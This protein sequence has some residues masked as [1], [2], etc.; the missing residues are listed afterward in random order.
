[1]PV[2]SLALK[3]AAGDPR[4]LSS[5]LPALT[6]ICSTSQDAPPPPLLRE[7]RQTLPIQLF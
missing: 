2:H 4:Q 5:T 3:H 6:S 1:M 7:P